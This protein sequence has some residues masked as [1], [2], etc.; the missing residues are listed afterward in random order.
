MRHLLRLVS[1]RHLS[2]APL[3]STLTVLGVAVGVATTVGIVA[4]NGSVVEALRPTIDSIAGRADLTVAAGVSGFEESAL[5]L[6]KATPG[7]AHASA[8]LSAVAP[9]K[10]SPGESLYVL[11]VDLLDDGHFREY[12]G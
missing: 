3:R 8:A 6:V 7:V 4:V 1:L 9:V 5:E 10:G 11:G 2:L 12:R